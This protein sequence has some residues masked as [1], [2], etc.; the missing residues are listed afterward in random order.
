MSPSARDAFRADLRSAEADPRHSVVAATR[1]GRARLFE[2]WMAF[3]NS[4]G[5]N[6]YL[7][8]VPPDHHLDIFIVYACRYRRG[9]V[10]RSAQPIGAQRVEEALR[11][12]GQEFARLGIPDPRLDGTSYIFCLKTLFKAWADSDPAP[13]RV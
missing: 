11:A 6:P 7:R 1:T 2:S 12:V 9:S 5:C 13:S 4:L 10:S 8:D 3:T